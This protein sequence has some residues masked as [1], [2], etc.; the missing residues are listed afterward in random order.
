MAFAGAAIRA[1]PAVL[2][3]VVPPPQKL[4]PTPH[5]DSGGVRN[6]KRKL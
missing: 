2:N 4:F 5:G 6:A 1:S 3:Q